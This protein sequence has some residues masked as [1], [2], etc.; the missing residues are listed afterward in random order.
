MLWFGQPLQVEALQN[1]SPGMGEP[2]SV[3]CKLALNPGGCMGFAMCPE[4]LLVWG[5]PG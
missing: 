1:F 3:R 4:Y 5:L 2:G